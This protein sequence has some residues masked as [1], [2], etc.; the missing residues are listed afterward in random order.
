MGRGGIKKGEVSAVR[1]GQEERRA[2]GKGECWRKKNRQLPAS[3]ASV[4][5]ADILSLL[6][7][8]TSL[9]NV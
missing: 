8:R 6:Q 1:L 5:M 7:G 9:W 3:K 4:N 2:Y